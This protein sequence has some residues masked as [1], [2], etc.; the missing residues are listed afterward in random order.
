MMKKLMVI[1]GS[2][3]ISLVLLVIFPSRSLSELLGYAKAPIRLS[4]QQLR[5]DLL[6]SCLPEQ[7][8]FPR[9]SARK[10]TDC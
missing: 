9:N 5:I 1:A 6:K 10:L 2:S 4:K 8:G 3:L 7:N